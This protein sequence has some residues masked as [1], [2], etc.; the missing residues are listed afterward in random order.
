MLSARNRIPHRALAGLTAAALSGVA[1]LGVGAVPA[2][3]TAGSQ[4]VAIANAN[5]GK[6]YC[7]TNSAGGTSFDS[8]CTANNGT[9]EFWCGD[10]VSWVWQQ[11]GVPVPAS[12]PASVPSWMS[13]SAYHALSSGYV[14]QPGDAV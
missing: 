7:S 8:S 3:A 11:A 13:T 1:L 4:I 12:A 10:F 9:G 5:L 14:P 2:S 6:G